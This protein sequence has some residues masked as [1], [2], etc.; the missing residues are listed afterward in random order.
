[1]IF[2][3]VTKISRVTKVAYDVSHS[4]LLPKFIVRFSQYLLKTS[5]KYSRLADIVFKFL[6]TLNHISRYFFKY[7]CIYYGIVTIVVTNITM[8]VYELYNLTV[9]VNPDF[10]KY[11]NSLHLWICKYEYYI[12]IETCKQEGLI[13]CDILMQNRL[14]KTGTCLTWYVFCQFL[15]CL[16]TK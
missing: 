13:I 4:W 10:L 8:F 3:L 11:H 7:H 1:M 14:E 2:L 9:N 16:D 6:T 5:R 12:F 15:L